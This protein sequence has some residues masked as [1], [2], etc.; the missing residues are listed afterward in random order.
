MN[1]K[2]IKCPCCGKESV[3]EYG[4]C[5]VCGWENDPIQKE[6]PNLK[7]CANRMSLRTCLH[8]EDVI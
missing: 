3:R 4:I 5:D 8:K 7:G 1:T 6:N 2:E